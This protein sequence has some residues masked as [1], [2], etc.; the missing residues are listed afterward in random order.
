MPSPRLLDTK[1]LWDVL[2]LNEFF[3]A[4]PR[5]K[6]ANDNNEDSGSEWDED[7][8]PGPREKSNGLNRNTP[9]ALRH[10]LRLRSCFL[11]LSAGK[12]RL[13]SLNKKKIPQTLI[14]GLG[15]IF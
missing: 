1:K 3:D 2:E 8:I 11:P 13:R 4:L 9:S 5:A 10:G 6:E 12:P 14:Q 15:K 7:S